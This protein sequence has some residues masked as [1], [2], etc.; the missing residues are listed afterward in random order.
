MVFSGFRSDHFYQNYHHYGNNG[1]N[2]EICS[3][4]YVWPDPRSRLT[5][6]QPSIF[7]TERETNADVPEKA[8][9]TYINTSP[10]LVRSF[11]S[12]NFTMLRW[13]FKLIMGPPWGVLHPKSGVFYPPTRWLASLAISLRRCPTPRPGVYIKQQSCGRWSCTHRDQMRYRTMMH[14]IVYI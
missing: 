8:S 5:K 4:F 13:W 1:E 3:I 6:C 14:Y 11:T 9:H 10:H 2:S 12:I 7:K